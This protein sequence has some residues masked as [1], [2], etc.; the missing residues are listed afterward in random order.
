MILSVIS[1]GASPTIAAI[2]AARFEDGPEG[3]KKIF[4][5][6]SLGKKNW[7]WI[8]I[9]IILPLVFSLTSATMLVVIGGI[10]LSLAGLVAFLPL[11]ASNLIMNVWEEIGWRGYALPTLQRKYSALTS[12]VIVGVM[13][14]LWH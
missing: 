11:L 7:G 12:A 6:F 3:P 2:I 14:S 9:S 10:E 8:A 13:W 5:Q 4:R 1:G